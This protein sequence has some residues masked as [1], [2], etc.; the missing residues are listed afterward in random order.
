MTATVSP[1]TT[2]RHREFG[3]RIRAL[4]LARGLTQR[5]LAERVGCD[6]EPIRR[7]EHSD[8]TTV[9]R[10]V[11]AIAD[12]LD[13]TGADLFATAEEFTAAPVGPHA[14]DADAAALWMLPLARRLSAAVRDRDTRRIAALW[15]EVYQQDMPAGVHPAE[16]L[17]LA[18]A[19][20]LAVRIGIERNRCMG[21]TAEV[22]ERARQLPGRIARGE[23]AVRTWGG[24]P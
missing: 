13:V 4:R 3:D 16:V 19:D 17:A 14:D 5:Q 9:L 21:L 2:R 22:A 20:E 15:A 10:R 7:I 11:F 23:Q 1:H 12:A 24:R 8:H 18:L 6:I